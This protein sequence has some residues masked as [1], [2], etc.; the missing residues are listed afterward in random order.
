MLIFSRVSS[1]KLTTHIILEQQSRIRTLA[2]F[3]LTLRDRITKN[4]FCTGNDSA[5]VLSI[6]NQCLLYFVAKIDSD[7]R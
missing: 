1:G 3:E 7:G 4:A 2:A 5:W 6:N